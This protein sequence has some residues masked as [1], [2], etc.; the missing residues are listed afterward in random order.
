MS[1][2]FPFVKRTSKFPMITEHK[3]L[4]NKYI[5][6]NLTFFVMNSLY[7]F[8]CQVSRMGIVLVFLTLCLSGI[9]LVKGDNKKKK[10]SNSHLSEGWQR[11]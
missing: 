9:S 10:P 5:I 2:L 6:T 11:S 4:K 3:M 1:T 7:Y 8:I